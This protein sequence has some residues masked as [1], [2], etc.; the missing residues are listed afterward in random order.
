MNNEIVS[1]IDAI[2]NAQIMT[3]F[4]VI[5]SL[6]EEFDK[7]FMI[8]ENCNNIDVFQ[9]SKGIMDTVK[10][11]EKNDSNKFISVLKFIPR[12]IAAMFKKLVDTFKKSDAK[13][14]IDEAIDKIEKKGDAVS[15]QARVIKL[16]KEANGECEF[17][18][19]EKHDKIKVKHDKKS[20]L[21]KAAWLGLH[22][23]LI[24]DL[25]TRI[26]DAKDI[27]NPSVTKVFI[28]DCDKIIH[29]DKGVSK[30]DFFNHGL[31]AIK[32]IF[33]D[34]KTVSE[35]TTLISHDIEELSKR[36][37]NNELCKDVPSEKKMEA[38]K[39][40][41]ELTNKLT[42]IAGIVTGA[43]ASVKVIT[44]WF[45]RVSTVAGMFHDESDRKEDYKMYLMM[46][47]G[48]GF[49]IDEI[50]R[51]NPKGAAESSDEY[52]NRIESIIK[53]T[54][55]K[56]CKEHPDYDKEFEDKK[57]KGVL[58]GHYDTWDNNN[59]KKAKEDYKAAKQKEHDDLIEERKKRKEEKK[60][61]KEN[62]K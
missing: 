29:G 7:C 14:N 24:L 42:T 26:K 21:E 50:K 25:I 33:K 32:H 46:A 44:K 16:N 15:K 20:I 1:L 19:D 55:T 47:D 8:M 9:E 51:D 38:L 40:I 13:K 34:C 48:T 17:Y 3:E 6:T 62:K 11:K 41:N 30:Y 53:K 10:E 35:A 27:T 23:D 52:A 61:E 37:S 60:K 45:D 5:K 59:I 49:D 2:D 54:I 39:N 28:S 58:N 56:Y 57:I 22:V 12:I 18:Y 4:S 43:C 36:L 31:E